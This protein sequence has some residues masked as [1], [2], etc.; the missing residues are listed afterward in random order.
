MT[1]SIATS[2]LEEGELSEGEFED[3]YEPRDATIVNLKLA[4]KRDESVDDADG[5]SI[6]DAATPNR[7]P[8]T[9]PSLPMAQQDSPLD[10]EWEPTTA[11]RER[12][13]SYSPYLSPQE[14]NRKVLTTKPVLLNNTGSSYSSLQWPV[15]N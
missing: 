2:S 9:S 12:S 10:D 11:D 3:L 5:S 6:Y 1:Q 15:I 7:L 14:V 13:G 4:E 8:I